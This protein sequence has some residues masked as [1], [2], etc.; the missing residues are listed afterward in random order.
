MKTD[1][2]V[3]S[4]KVAQRTSGGDRDVLS[5]GEI[6]RLL[7]ERL[8]QVIEG[9]LVEAEVIVGDN[10]DEQPKVVPFQGRQITEH[11]NPQDVSKTPHLDR[12]VQRAG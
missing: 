4:V 8:N 1:S 11:L 5:A 2:F 6:S 12:L 10:R 7:V 9:L 3:I